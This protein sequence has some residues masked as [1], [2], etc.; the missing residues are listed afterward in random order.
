MPDRQ[1][2][3]RPRRASHESTG[4]LSYGRTGV[5]HDGQREPGRESDSPR[6]RR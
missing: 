6:G 1:L 4:T 5:P 3:H 2:R